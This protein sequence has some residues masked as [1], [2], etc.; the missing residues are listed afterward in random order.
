MAN[1]DTIDEPFKRPSAALMAAELP[2]A[3]L[4]GIALTTAVPLLYSA[5]NGDGH[6]VLVLPGFMASDRSTEILREFLSQKKYAPEPWLLGRNLGPRGKLP[7]M[8]LGRVNEIYART[9]RKVSLV[10][11]SL[12][13]VYAREIAKRRPDAVRQVISLGSPFGMGGQLSNTRPLYDQLNADQSEAPSH[14]IHL[15]PPVPSTSIFSKTDGVVAWQSCLEPETDITE[16]IEVQG[17][18]CGLGVNGFVL[19]A[20]AER[21]SQPQDQWRPFAKR[22]WRRLAYK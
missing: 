10:G 3:F 17:S 12:G 18:H 14:G 19:Y 11:W 2:R 4:E 15:P 22:G 8:M 21:L 5:P 20:I 9:G 6:P 13:G 1:I 16:N 7:E